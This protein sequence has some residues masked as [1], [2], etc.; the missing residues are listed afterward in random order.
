M[1]TRLRYPQPEN[2]PQ[3]QLLASHHER[4]GRHEDAGWFMNY[5]A[6]LAE[7]NGY[8]TKVICELHTASA[9]CWAKA[10]IKSP[11]RYTRQAIAAAGVAAVWRHELRK[12][13]WRERKAVAMTG[14]TLARE[15]GSHPAE[16]LTYLWA[17]IIYGLDEKERAFRGR[18]R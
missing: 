14:I 13:I 15:L 9:E 5:A 18:N 12:E 4:L 7:E 17:L 1:S 10:A 6:R 8:S 3:A 2:V 16:T 11:L